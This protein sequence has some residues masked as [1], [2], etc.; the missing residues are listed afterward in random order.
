MR[1]VDALTRTAVLA[2]HGGSG[3]A[4]AGSVP[5]TLLQD[6][7]AK[8][9]DGTQAGFYYEPAKGTSEAAL[10]GWVIHLQGGGE[11]SDESSCAKQLST[12][13]GSSKYF[14]PYLWDLTFLASN[15]ADHNPLMYDWNHVFVPYCSQDLHSGQVTVPSNATF[16][17]FFSGHLSFDA[18]VQVLHDSSFWWVVAWELP[19]RLCSV[20]TLPAES[21]RG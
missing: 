21:G 8:C 2:V 10:G 5:L 19:R 12:S 4:R 20:A 14:D 11:C 15:N 7:N 6:P 18:I 1:F 3:T 9:L 17:F 13:R 16:D